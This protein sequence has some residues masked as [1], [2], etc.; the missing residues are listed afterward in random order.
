MLSNE[1]LLFVAFMAILLFFAAVEIV[2][3]N[4]INLVRKDL[5]NQINDLK[6]QIKSL[7]KQIGQIP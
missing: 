6:T 4:E 3:Y 5:Q 2:Q 1:F 7:E